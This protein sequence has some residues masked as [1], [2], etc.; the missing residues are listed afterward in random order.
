M[1]KRNQSRINHRKKFLSIQV[2][3]VGSLVPGL[4]LWFTYKSRNRFDK[5]TFI[6]FLYKDNEKNV[7]HGLN[8]NYVKDS[9]LQTFFSLLNK[10]VDIKLEDEAKF[11]KDP[12]LRVALKGKRAPQGKPVKQVYDTVIRRFLKKH[13]CYRTYRISD[14][15]GLK[16]IN[17][18]LDILKEKKEKQ[19]QETEEQIE[20]KN[21]QKD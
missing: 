17:F 18:D 10:T 14:I 3:K 9:L 5:M 16:I 15:K 11:I 2:G 8:L 7:I 19:E 21:N 4:F 6:L 12:Y 1:P 20:Q 13:D